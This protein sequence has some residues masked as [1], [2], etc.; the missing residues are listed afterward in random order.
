VGLNLSALDLKIQKP[1]G[2]L[3]LV[4]SISG[5]SKQHAGLSHLRLLEISRLGLQGPLQVG[6]DFSLGLAALFNLEHLDIS[7]NPLVN[8]TLPDMFAG[9]QGCPQ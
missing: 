1:L 4:E 7:S 5:S 3:Q 6:S 9:K 8:G 2:L